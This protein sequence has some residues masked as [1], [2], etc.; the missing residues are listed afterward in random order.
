MPDIA[1]YIGRRFWYKICFFF[2]CLASYDYGERKKNPGPWLQKASVRYGYYDGPASSSLLDEAR[3][4]KA[5]FMQVG[6]KKKKKKERIKK[7]A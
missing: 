2:L 7:E 6:R 1:V 5:E 4:A 3:E